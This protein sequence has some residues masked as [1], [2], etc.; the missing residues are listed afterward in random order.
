M[1]INVNGYGDFEHSLTVEEYNEIY[2]KLVKDNYGDNS[3]A[4]VNRDGFDFNDAFSSDLDV[5]TDFLKAHNNGFKEGLMIVYD[6]DYCG[7]MRWECGKWVDYEAYPLCYFT[8]QDLIKELK[9]RGI[10]VEEE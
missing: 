2:N 6:G 3:P 5:L 7:A 9:Y 8:N 10:H 1:R 4:L